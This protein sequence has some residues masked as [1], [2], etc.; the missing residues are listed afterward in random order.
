MNKLTRH[1][2]AILTAFLP[3]AGS[4]G[5]LRA[6]PAAESVH[7]ADSLFVS[8]DIAI[9]WAVLREPAQQTAGEKAT[10]W[11]R[12]V[13]RSGAFSRLSI[14]GVD[15]FTG[16][17]ER[18]ESGVELRGE[19]RIGADRDRFS[20]LP[21]REL[22]FYRSDDDWRADRPALN[23]YYLGVPDT[24]PEFGTRAAM[25]SYLDGARL[26]AHPVMRKP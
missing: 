26:V 8:P 18:L 9:V 20:D 6:Q 10:V 11:L 22:H 16:T 12:V 5:P 17:R 25:D 7:G 3:L 21:S 1:A 4:L 13:N 19:A 24:T 15:P 23:V 2:L 14:E